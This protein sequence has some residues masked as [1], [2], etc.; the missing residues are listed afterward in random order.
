MNTKK[1]SILIALT[2]STNALRT[3]ILDLEYTKSDLVA[4]EKTTAVL[5]SMKAIHHLFA[6]STDNATLEKAFAYN[7]YVNEVTDAALEGGNDISRITRLADTCSKAKESLS[8]QKLSEWKGKD[9]AKMSA[10]LAMALA[11]DLG[12]CFA[13]KTIKK[14]LSHEQHRLYRRGLYVSKNVLLD[15]LSKAALTCFNN[16]VNGT[17]GE[18][19]KK[20]V[21]SETKNTAWATL[22]SSL[23]TQIVGEILVSTTQDDKPTDEA[24]KT[25]AFL[26]NL[27]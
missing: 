16:M 27:V 2:I 9:Y 18:A 21:W 15:C 19:Q 4:V 24:L 23:A 5:G 25:N 26:N 12:H 14:N 7:G 6:G 10:A 17:E 1:L 20:S 8:T 13:G 22:V 11:L 3:D